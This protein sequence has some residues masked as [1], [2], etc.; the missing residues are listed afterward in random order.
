M[1]RKYEKEESSN[2]DET[3]DETWT[4]GSCCSQ[5]SE[6]PVATPTGV[7]TRSRGPVERPPAAQADAAM[8]LADGVVDDE[9]DLSSDTESDE[10]EGDDEDSSGEEEEEEESEEDDYSDDDSFVTSNE[11]VDRGD[12]DEVIK[13]YRKVF[14]EGDDESEY[15]DACDEVE[16]DVVVGDEAFLNQPPEVDLSV[17]GYV[18]GTGEM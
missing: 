13:S 10:E 17:G 8:D 4:P 5:Q 7:R 12:R 2:D 9:S 15:D 1:K 6:S 14:E 11:D 18:A 16:D 3:S